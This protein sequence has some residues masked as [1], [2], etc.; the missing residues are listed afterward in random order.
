MDMNLTLGM[1]ADAMPMAGRKGTRSAQIISRRFGKNNRTCGRCRMFD[2][3]AANH[4]GKTTMKKTATA[5]AALVLTVMFVRG[6]D[7]YGL[8]PE[9]MP[10]FEI[11]RM[12]RPP[13]IDGAIDAQE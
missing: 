12:S 13:V 1:S 2:S 11:P 7:D 8:P 6:A 3:N 10:T 4:K 5:I 9:A